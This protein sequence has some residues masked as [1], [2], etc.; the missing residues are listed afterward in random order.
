MKT[1]IS[2]PAILFFFLAFS[3]VL[4]LVMLSGCAT[5]DQLTVV[6][7]RNNSVVVLGPEDVVAVMRRAWFTDEQI[8]QLGLEL[9]DALASHGA[10][11][12]QAAD[13]TEALFLTEGNFIYVTVRGHGSFFYSR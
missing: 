6:P 9:R 4:Q 5:D 2:R 12:V 13:C 1:D 11:R 7:C 8:E 3:I 10:A